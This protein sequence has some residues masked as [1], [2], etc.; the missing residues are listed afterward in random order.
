MALTPLPEDWTRALCVAAHPDDL[1]Y[2]T[3]SAVHRWTS[4]GRHVSYLLVTRGEAGIDGLTPDE[5]GPLRAAEEVEGASRVG[6]TQ[7]DFLDEVDG[8]VVYSLDL[9]RQLARVMRRVKPDLVVTGHFGLAWGPGPGGPANQADHRA[10]GLATLDAARDAGNR[11]IFPDL[12][13]EG[14]EPHHVRWVAVVG[15]PTPSHSVVIDEADLEAGIASLEA[16]GRYLA[17][18]STPT[19]VRAFLTRTAEDGGPAADSRYAVLVELF[20]T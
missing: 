6:V 18:L 11:W 9:R 10:V 5:C 16:H 13:D 12:L 20:D 1:E 15:T 4:Q 19:D 14:L 17:G 3:A 8:A 2:G 7:V